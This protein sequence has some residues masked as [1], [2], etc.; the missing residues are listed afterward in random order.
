[1][2][3]KNIVPNADGEGQLGTSSKS[4]AEGHIDSITG[5]ISTAAQGSIT[6]LG[7]LTSLN[8]SGN[9]GIGTTSPSSYFVRGGG[10]VVDS[11]DAG[12]NVVILNDNNTFS[13]LFFAKG[14]TGAEKYQGYIEYEHANEAMAFGTAQVERM[15]LSSAGIEVPDS[16]NIGCASDTDLLTLSSAQVI[17]DGNTGQGVLQLA[18]QKA[19]GSLIA[20]QSI[21]EINFRHNH[22]ATA[23]TVTSARIIGAA[24]ENT[25]SGQDNHGGQ[26][27][28][29]TAA[30]GNNET[31]PVKRLTIGS[32]SNATFAGGVAVTGA[33]SLPLSDSSALNAGVQIPTN[34]QLGFGNGDGSKPDFGFAVQGTSGSAKLNI[35]CG[36]GGTDVDAFIDTNGF[37]HAAA[38]FLGGETSANTLDDYE[39]GTW[40]PS[41]TTSTTSS[42]VAYNIRN[43][44]YTK[45]GNQVTCWG[46]IQTNATTWNGNYVQLDGQPFAAANTTMPIGFIAYSFGFA[47]DHPSGIYYATSTRNY[48]TYRDAADGQTNELLA[49]DMNTGNGVNTIIFSFTFQTT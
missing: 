8:I 30:D 44:Y 9:V 41:Y 27:E 17:L 43:G 42:T 14:S 11:V 46:N 4:W 33:S 13:S 45:V 47:G 34:A 12:S 15:Q 29:Y 48:L 5:T 38:L 21:G 24:A 49:S 39:E 6:S 20:G 26:L 25:V 31:A 16:S 18:T 1:M 19:A 36:T 3:T 32:D 22:A 7:T 37:I 35:F 2:A 10:L 40:T 28:F 23:A